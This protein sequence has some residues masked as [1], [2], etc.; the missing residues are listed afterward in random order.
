MFL[1]PMLRKNPIWIK[2]FTGIR[3]EDFWLMIDQME[4]EFFEYEIDRHNRDDRKRAVGA[5]RKFEQ[6]LAQ[7]T[8]GVLAY[9]RLHTSQTVIATMFGLEQYE[10]S[11]D[12]RRLLPMIRDVLPCPEIWEVNDHDFVA[13]FPEQLE[14]G[15]ALIDAT[16]QRVSRPGRNNQ[17]RKLFFSGKQ[18]EFTLKTQMATDGSWHIAAISEPVPGSIHDKKLCDQLQT[19]EHLPTGCEVG[20]DKGY[21]GLATDSVSTISV[22]NAEAGV[23]KQVPRVTAY[24]PFK[25]PKGQELTEQQKEFNR[26]LA[27]IRI[28]VEHCIGWIKNWAILATRFRCSHSIYGLVMQTICGLVNQQTLRRKMAAG[29][30]AYCA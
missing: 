3:A 30:F 25:K 14:D 10:I 4:T 12:L 9:L 19:L 21:Q 22:H 5:G 16:E 7:R 20:A 2:F 8:V 18:S 13:M 27:S 28:R 24:T 15:L 17:I 11:R 6:S 29:A 1:E 26:A 23:E